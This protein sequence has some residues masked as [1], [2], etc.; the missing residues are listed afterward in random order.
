[1]SVKI[2]T[3]QKRLAW[4]PRSNDI[5]ETALHRQWEGG[6]VIP[7]ASMARH[8][9]ILEHGHWWTSSALWEAEAAKRGGLGADS[10]QF[11]MQKGSK[12]KDA[13]VL[14]DCKCLL[15]ELAVSGLSQLC[16]TGLAVRV[17]W[18]VKFGQDLWQGRGGRAASREEQMRHE[19]LP[20]LQ[21]ELVEHRSH[22]PIELVLGPRQ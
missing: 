10:S 14:S 17:C 22:Q 19:Q 13:A 5:L 15:A 7:A 21:A 18:E 11:V 6:P 12:C 9:Q 16:A 1:M 8:L 4:P 3:I 2:G 20:S